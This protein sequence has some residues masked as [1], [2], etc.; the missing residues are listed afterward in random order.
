M[1]RTF[2]TPLSGRDPPS[3]AKIFV[4][5]K[6][7]DFTR[8]TVER[9]DLAPTLI[10]PAAKVV[11]LDSKFPELLLQRKRA[12]PPSSKNVR[13]SDFSHSLS[14]FARS[15]RILATKIAQCDLGFGPSLFDR[16][17]EHALRYRQEFPKSIARVLGMSQFL[18][19]QAQTVKDHP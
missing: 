15:A 17:C 11:L 16:R 3:I 8:T 1:R 9:A 2:E 19:E 14:V 18:V 12:L 4:K 10:D 7:S 13:R 6:F 5:L